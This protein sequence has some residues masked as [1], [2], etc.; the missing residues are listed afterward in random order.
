MYVLFAYLADKVVEVIMLPRTTLA[1]ICVPMSTVSI[2]REIFGPL[3]GTNFVCLTF[4]AEQ[5]VHSRLMIHF[6]L[7]TA[8]C[9]GWKQRAI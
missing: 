3:A 8:A 1:F 6:P 5:V 4:G 7:K 9:C 2:L